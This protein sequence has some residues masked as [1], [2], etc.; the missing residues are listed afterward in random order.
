MAAGGFAAFSGIGRARAQSSE[1]ATSPDMVVVPCMVTSNDGDIDN[2]RPNYWATATRAQYVFLAPMRA[3]AESIVLFNGQEGREPRFGVAAIKATVTRMD[4]EPLS[5]EHLEIHWP[6]TVFQQDGQFYSVVQLAH[7]QKVPIG[8]LLGA[9]AGIVGEVILPEAYDP[10][11]TMVTFEPAIE[12]TIHQ[13]LMRDEGFSAKLIAGGKVYSAVEPDTTKYVALIATLADAMDE[14]RRMDAETQCT[15]VDDGLQSF[16]DCFLTSACCAV[17]GLTDDCWELA[18][19]RRFRDGYMQGFAEGRADI[20]RY[21]A[22]APAIAQG[23]VSSAEGRRRL[24]G[25]YWRTI[26]PAVV[27]ARLGL[28]RTAHAVY[29]RMMLDLLPAVRAG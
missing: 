2:M 15:A 13:A 26:L 8:L 29:R 6:L 27:L 21:Y 3:V 22:E 18:T 23:L 11:Q 5:I 20:G 10:N 28:N 17:L 4:D 25:L 14:A 16:D 24:L 7:D 1:P 19:L 12:T 9:G